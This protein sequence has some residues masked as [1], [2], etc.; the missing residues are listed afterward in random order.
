MTPSAAED[1]LS[2]LFGGISGEV[3]SRT[4]EAEPQRTSYPYLSQ[5]NTVDP[6]QMMM[7]VTLLSSDTSAQKVSSL[8]TLT[9]FI[10]MGK[11]KRWRI[12]RRSIK[13]ARR[14]TESRREITKSKIVGRLWLVGRRI[15]SRCRCF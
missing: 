14:T 6:Q 12:K 15:N 9:R 5:V 1:V 13:T 10:W 3:T 7:M 11:L 4:E 2:K 8:K